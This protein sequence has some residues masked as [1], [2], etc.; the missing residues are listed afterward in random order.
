MK[1]Q[2]VGRPASGEIYKMKTFNLPVRMIKK[3]QSKADRQQRAKQGEGNL[4]LWLRNLLEGQFS[5]K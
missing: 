2:K 4:S 3:M 1:K 5:S